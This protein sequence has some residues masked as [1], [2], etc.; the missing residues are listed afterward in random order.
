MNKSSKY[1]FPFCIRYRYLVVVISVFSLL[2]SCLPNDNKDLDITQSYEFIYS[3]FQLSK[4]AEDKF[5][6]NSSMFLD[7][8]KLNEAATL[9]T[10]RLTILLDSARSTNQNSLYF[11]GLAKGIDI[12]NYQSTALK[13]IKLLNNLDNNE[14]KEFIHSLNTPSNDRYIK[15]QQLLS[16]KQPELKKLRDE[17]RDAAHAVE[18][19][20]H[21]QSIVDS[22][23]DVK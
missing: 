9:D 2:I 21:I 19:K 4:N 1:Y 12:K 15:A 7:S 14:Y 11:I 17:F 5:K 23:Q 20:Y 18:D 16:A 10:K 13:Y 3:S 6:E 8:I 22:L